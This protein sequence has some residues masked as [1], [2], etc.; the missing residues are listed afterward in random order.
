MMQGHL[1]MAHARGNLLMSGGSAGPE[2][3]L[4]GLPA[5]VIG[6]SVFLRA[7]KRAGLFVKGRN[8]PELL[9]RARGAI[10]L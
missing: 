4:L 7:V 1:F 9:R 5:Q 3:S 10:G 8:S 2:G 6:L